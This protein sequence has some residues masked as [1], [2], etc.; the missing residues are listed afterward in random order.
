MSFQQIISLLTAYKYFFL[1]PIVV[2]EGPI[3]TVIAGFLSS[4]GYLNIII[5]YLVVVAGDIVGDSA[6]YA[7]GFY[8]RKK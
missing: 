6:Y 8:G 5:A 1:F 2:V 3:I 7:I 4:L